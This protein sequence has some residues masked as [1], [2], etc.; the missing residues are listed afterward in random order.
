MGRLAL[1]SSAL[2]AFW[3]LAAC[4]AP[5]AVG[6]VAQVIVDP[7][8]QVGEDEDQPSEIALHV[9]AGA[10]ANPNF[11]QQ[12]SPT[13]LQIFAL[14]G[15]HRFLSFDF[16]SL[17]EDPEG[18]LG[19]TLKELLGEGQI[20][21]DQYAIL[22]PYVLPRGTSQIGV[23]AEFLD[24]DGTNW[25]TTIDVEDIGADARLLLLVLEEEI[26]LLDEDG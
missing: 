22:G 21:P 25:R 5:E 8:I 23:I 19:V 26:R 9:Y 1:L 13:V 15:D 2:G 7:D 20:A 16:F 11:D 3:L 6:K 14:D 24:I 4:E 10:E 12:P 17:V 18:T